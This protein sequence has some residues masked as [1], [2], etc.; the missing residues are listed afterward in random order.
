MKS[1]AVIA[2][3]CKHVRGPKLRAC[4]CFD[5]TCDL[6]N[7]T[8]SPRW[9]KTIAF[10]QHG[11]GMKSTQYKKGRPPEIPSRIAKLVTPLSVWASFS[12]HS[13]KAS[14]RSCHASAPR[15]LRGASAAKDPN[16]QLWNYCVLREDSEIGLKSWSRNVTS[17]FA[18]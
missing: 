5:S 7:L 14:S 3:S 4:S 18:M 1:F 13:S 15:C 8:P 16:A 12:G 17:N 11:A 9:M 10:C 2:C 6:M